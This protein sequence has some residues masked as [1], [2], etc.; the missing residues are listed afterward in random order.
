MNI[1]YWALPLLFLLQKR[2]GSLRRARPTACQRSLPKYENSCSPLQLALRQLQES[3]GQFQAI[4]S[5]FNCIL[6]I[7]I[8]RSGK[9]SL[10]WQLQRSPEVRTIPT[11]VLY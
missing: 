7:I 11:L 3:L 1:Q 8:R 9:Y 2:P 5:Q 6:K 4:D 10:P